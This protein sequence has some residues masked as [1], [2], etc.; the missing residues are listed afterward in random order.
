MNSPTASGAFNEGDH[1]VVPCKHCSS[2]ALA[3]EV[4][5][6]ALLVKCAKCGKI[7]RLVIERDASGWV[8]RSEAPDQP[9]SASPS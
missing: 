8:I 4:K 7:T 2:V 1:I 3:F 9:P 5:V 6:G